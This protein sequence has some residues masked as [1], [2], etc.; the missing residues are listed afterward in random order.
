MI[1]LIDIL[2]HCSFSISSASHNGR[3]LPWSLAVPLDKNS[4]SSMDMNLN[5]ERV[6]EKTS[7]ETEESCRVN[8]I[9]ARNYVLHSRTNLFLF[10]LP[11]ASI[12]CL[13]ISSSDF[14][15]IIPFAG[16]IRAQ[17]QQ[18]QRKKMSQRP[19]QAEPTW[20]STW[21]DREGNKKIDLPELRTAVRY[22]YVVMEAW[23]Q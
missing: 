12:T 23:K 18:Q 19:S 6:R 22:V 15:Y 4:C 20:W 9:I 3:C 16:I 13:R 17:Q 7:R 14:H 5:G 8:E 11:T 2:I 1:N 21:E 10:C